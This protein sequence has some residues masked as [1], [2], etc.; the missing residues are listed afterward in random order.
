MAVSYSDLVYEACSELNQDD[1]RT[2][3]GCNG[4]HGGD[5]SIFFVILVIIGVCVM[6]GLVW[7]HLK[8]TSTR[9][10]FISQKAV[11]NLMIIAALAVSHWVTYLAGESAVETRLQLAASPSPAISPTPFVDRHE[12]LDRD[13]ILILI[14]EE[15]IKAGLHPLAGGKD[16]DA[17]AQRIVEKIATSGSCLHSLEN[18][19]G[20]SEELA[21]GV[22]TAPETVNGWMNSLTHRTAILNP[23]RRSIGIGIRGT[24]V[25]II[26]FDQP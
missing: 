5:N 22:T 4:D 25:V 8:K 9:E 7:D 24:T 26:L 11:R 13:N 18:P 16:R 6:I 15:R 17:V 1:L 3:P 12:N 20:T 14:N 10:A 23:E 2:A 19:G 21:C